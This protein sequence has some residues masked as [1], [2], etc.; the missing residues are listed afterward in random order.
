MSMKLIPLHFPRCDGFRK[1]LPLVHQQT[2]C[3]K[4]H[5]NAVLCA[6][7]KNRYG[8]LALNKPN[9]LWRFGC[10]LKLFFANDQLSHFKRGQ[11]W[12]ENNQFLYC[13]KPNFSNELQNMALSIMVRKRMR[14][15]QFVP[16]D[17][18]FG[19]KGP[20]TR[21]WACNEWI[22]KEKKVRRAQ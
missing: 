19:V 8:T 11:K 16:S 9:L 5:L 1:N 4:M 18:K 21:N 6:L 7:K 3:T 17:L 14:N 22:D 13:F 10:R 12:P 2:T 15:E 20:C